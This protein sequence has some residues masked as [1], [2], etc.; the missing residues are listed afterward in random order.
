M[1]NGTLS[2]VNTGPMDE[3]H[4]EGAAISVHFIHDSNNA[5]DR[6]KGIYNVLTGV[7]IEGSWLYGKVN[8]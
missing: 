3:V 1:D 7:Y 5:Y 2:M 8:F 6:F 4:H